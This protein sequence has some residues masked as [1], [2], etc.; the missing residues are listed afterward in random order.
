M[1]FHKILTITLFLT[2]FVIVAFNA[3]VAESQ[4]SEYVT[5]G[6]IGFWTMDKADIQGDTV[7]DVSGN[8]NH[9]KIGGDPKSIDGKLRKPWISMEKMISLTYRIWEMKLPSVLIYGR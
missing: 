4:D 7:K 3:P 9:G 5:D 6:L 8:D 2:V 1:R